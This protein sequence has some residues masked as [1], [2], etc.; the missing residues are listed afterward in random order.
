MRSQPELAETVSA[1]LLSARGPRLASTSCTGGPSC[2]AVGIKKTLHHHPHGF[3]QGWGG[4][5]AAAAGPSR[6]RRRQGESCA[7][8]RVA[9]RERPPRVMVSTIWERKL[10]CSTK[11]VFVCAQPA[12]TPRVQISLRGQGRG[13]S[14][15][16]ETGRG[17][18]CA[19]GPFGLRR[20]SSRIPQL[21]K[22]PGQPKAV[23]ARC[24][25]RV[26]CRDEPLTRWGRSRWRCPCSIGSGAGVLWIPVMGG[27][28][29]LL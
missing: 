22:P 3:R 4:T 15:R 7:R 18:G 24:G 1:G 2:T 14:V 28:L 11:P 21:D 5:W 12:A 25:D 9:L 23:G 17:S 27:N 20:R 8:R 29:L 26:G 13:S 19:R 16:C 10:S 6:T